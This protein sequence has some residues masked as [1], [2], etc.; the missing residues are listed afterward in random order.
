MGAR[1]SS[2]SNTQQSQGQSFGQSYTASQSG[3]VNQSQSQNVAG[4]QGSQYGYNTGESFVDQGQQPFL[5]QLY[6]GQQGLSQGAYARPAAFASRENQGFLNNAMR[7]TNELMNPAEQIAAQ[8]ASLKAGLSNLFGNTL[9]PQIASQSVLAGGLGGGRQGVA[10]A[11]AMGELGQ[12]YTQGLGDITARANQ[13]AGMAAQFMPTLASANMQNRM[14]PILARAQ[15]L[16]DRAGI[17]GGP[18]VL[19]RSMAENM[20]ANRS[21]SRGQSSSYGRSFTDMLSQS[22]DIASQSAAAQGKQGSFGF[23]TLWLGDRHNGFS[24]TRACGA[25]G[26]QH[27]VALR[28]ELPGPHS[29]ELRGQ[30]DRRL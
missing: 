29:R 17:L 12:A 20:G 26:R 16:Q 8:E 15:S 30:G 27:G 18:T 11:N 9:M 19:Q 14:A 10:Q 4:S 1:G 28:A 21:F 7:V 6:R 25:C 22:F 24:F 3:S 2:S 5:Q 13:Q 23:Q